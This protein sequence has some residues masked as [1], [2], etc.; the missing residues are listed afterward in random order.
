MTPVEE[1]LVTGWPVWVKTV[2]YLLIT[3]SLLF[4]L[5]AAGRHM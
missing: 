3:V 2:A 5:W 4:A 1:I